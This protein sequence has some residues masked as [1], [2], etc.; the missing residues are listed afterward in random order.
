[1]SMWLP[2]ETVALPATVNGVFR[3]IHIYRHTSGIWLTFVFY[4]VYLSVKTIPNNVEKYIYSF[5]F[6]EVFSFSLV[7]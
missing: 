2:Y 1:M 5:G 4:L 7:T 3:C 6:S